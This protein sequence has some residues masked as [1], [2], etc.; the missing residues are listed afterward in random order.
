MTNQNAK[1]HLGTIWNDAVTTRFK[2]KWPIQGPLR[3][4]WHY[5]DI[6]LLR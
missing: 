4:L 1:Y 5:S 2:K 3:E 6:R